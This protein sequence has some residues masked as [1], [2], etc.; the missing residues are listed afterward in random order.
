MKLPI[1][2]TNVPSGICWYA[3]AVDYYSQDHKA[4]AGGDLHQT[5]DEFDLFN[6]L[7]SS[8]NFRGTGTYFTIPPHS[9]DLDDDQKSKQRDDPSSV[10]D[11]GSPWPVVDNVAGSRDFEGKDSQPTDG[12]LPT[13]SESKRGIDEAADVHGERPVDGIDYRQ[14]RESLHHNVAMLLN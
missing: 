7:P 3:T 8:E 9:K 5:E 14:L 2:C 12:V 6:Q 1:L 13:A 4:Y 10:G 11:V